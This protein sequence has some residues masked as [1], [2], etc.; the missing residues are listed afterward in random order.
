MGQRGPAPKP[1]ALKQLE[2]TFRP[3]RAQGEVFPDLPPD[4][5]PPDHLSEPARDKW[6]EL[7]PILAR[8]GLLTECD[9]DALALYCA[10]PGA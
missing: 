3:D 7:A 10:I 6:V 9:L 4:L 8:N 2:G 5:S 1:T